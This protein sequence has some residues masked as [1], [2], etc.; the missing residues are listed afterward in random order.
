[1]KLKT[2]TFGNGK[3]EL[4]QDYKTKSAIVDYLFDNLNL[5]DYRYSRVASSILDFY[6]SH[7]SK[8]YHCL[9]GIFDIVV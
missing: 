5:S 3:A 2:I 9:W 6:L 7:N 1:M 8:S 4:I